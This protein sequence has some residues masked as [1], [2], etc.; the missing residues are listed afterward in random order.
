RFNNSEIK[1]Q[2]SVLKQLVKLSLS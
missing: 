2:I 1:V